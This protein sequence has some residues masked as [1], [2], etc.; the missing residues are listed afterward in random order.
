MPAPQPLT[1]CIDPEPDS[2]AAAAAAIW[3]I[4]EGG[5]VPLRVTSFT[6]HHE[7]ALIS[8]G[9]VA[10]NVTGGGGLV[11]V[12]RDGCITVLKLHE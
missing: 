7:G 6:R 5:P 9:P 8:V 4:P 10:T 11:W 1:R 2:A 12:D 3:A